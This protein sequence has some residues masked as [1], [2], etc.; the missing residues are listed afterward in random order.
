MRS[1]AGGYAGFGERAID[2]L[3]PRFWT[4]PIFQRYP[5]IG[6]L[7]ERFKIGWNSFGHRLGQVGGQ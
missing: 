5:E 3:Q 4:V 7:L 6:S 1:H 2:L